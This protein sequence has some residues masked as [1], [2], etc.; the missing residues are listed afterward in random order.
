PRTL[1]LDA[2]I[3]H[4]LAHQREVI[5]RRT[6]FRL[7]R[8][9]RQAHVLEGLLV[10][11]SHLDEVIALIRGAADPGE[12]RERLMSRFDL[13][14]VQARGIP[15]LGLQRVTKLEAGKIRAE[16]DEL[17]RQILDLRRI[18]ADERRVDAVIREELHEIRER[19]ADARLT[20]IVPGEGE[21]DLEDLIAEE[22][23]V[24]SITR[25][26]YVKRLPVS[27]YRAQRHGGKGL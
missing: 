20:E 15:A 6:R 27:T 22:E 23:M 21:I 3:R 8:A 25:G 5:V 12:A 24:I 19:H 2:M 14:E 16:C 26:G 4:Y 13:T 10:A 1:S 11:L 18:L 17:R 9:E 7:A